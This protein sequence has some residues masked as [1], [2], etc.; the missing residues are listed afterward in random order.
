MGL[1]GRKKHSQRP[2]DSSSNST[3]DFLNSKDSARLGTNRLVNG[4]L[5]IS[6][7][8]QLLECPSEKPRCLCAIFYNA[9]LIEMRDMFRMLHAMCEKAKQE[10]FQMEDVTTFY[11]WFEGFFGI[12]TSVFDAEEDV[13]YSWVETA[14][15]QKLNIPL[16]PNRR[17]TKKQRA[18]DLCWD[19]FDLK[20]QF[21]TKNDR[22]TGSLGLLKEICNESQQL[23]NRVLMYF[24]AGQEELS[25]ILASYFGS[26]E[27]NLMESTFMGNLRATEPGKFTICAFARG[28]VDADE[29]NSFLEESL[30]ANKASKGAVTKQM[31]KYRKQHTEH[32]D[33]IADDGSNI[34]RSNSY[35]GP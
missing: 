15:A 1:L 14:G 13:L 33:T 7:P 8:L 6:I 4:V 18:K 2:S 27:Q 16:A 11:L 26:E 10:T 34:A 20:M 25:D 21:E 24:Q 23:A 30:R 5:D 35:E 31:R 28:F 29:R 12:L 22:G 32:V 3:Q 19:I 17:K 9:V